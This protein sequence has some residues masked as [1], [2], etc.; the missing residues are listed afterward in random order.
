M[1][2]A[3]K[4]KNH[5]FLF[6][7]EMFFSL[8]LIPC[9]LGFVQVIAKLESSEAW[10]SEEKLALLPAAFL[11]LAI[12]NILRAAGNRYRKPFPARRWVDLAFGVAFLVCSILLSNDLQSATAM[13]AAILVYLASVIAGR[14]LSIIQD[15][16]VV[17][18][19]LNAAVILAIGA[20]I[21]DGFLSSGEENAAIL[22]F[23]LEIMMV[24][25]AV[26]SFCRIMGAIFANI[27]L[28]VLRDV[29]KQTYAAE[30]IFGLVLLIMSFSWVLVYMD[31]S[32]DT[33]K[34][35]LWYCFAVV[36]TIGFGDLTASS[37][38]GR[39]LSVIL[40]VYGI[41]VVAL[42]TSVIVNFYGEMKK[43]GPEE[44][45]ALEPGDKTDKKN[46]SAPS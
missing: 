6:G 33:Y 14:V 15:H 19:V 10:M 42:V 29:V 36:T 16:R 46:E 5:N 4:L 9:G 34:D 24:F 45:P 23:F 18:T 20:F 3:K 38:V 44:E 43:A 1:K 27:R 37:F 28:D 30:I 39:I 22:P 21:I 13:W 41:I 35:A 8:L 26:G 25:L 40:G 7:L 11:C 12:A 2:T 32:F 17:K 31:S